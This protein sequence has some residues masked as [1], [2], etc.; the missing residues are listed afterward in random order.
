MDKIVLGHFIQE[1]K[2]EFSEEI[3]PE[4]NHVKI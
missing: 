2:V 3:D 1:V 4:N